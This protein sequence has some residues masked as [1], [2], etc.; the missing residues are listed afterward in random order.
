MVNILGYDVPELAAIVSV[1][2]VIL[3]SLLDKSAPTQALSR[4]EHGL[5]IALLC[6]LMLA[7]VITDPQRSLIMSTCWAVGVGYTGLPILGV[8]RARIFPQIGGLAGP[9]PEKPEEPS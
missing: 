4:L 9:A 5:L 7:L 6:I 1:I 8:I 2:V 3:A